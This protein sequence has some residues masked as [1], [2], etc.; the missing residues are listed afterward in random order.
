L[1]SKCEQQ[2]APLVLHHLPTPTP[3]SNANPKANANNN[4]APAPT[5]P[6]NN[7]NND[8]TKAVNLKKVPFDGTEASY[9]WTTQILGFA[10]T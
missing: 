5:T 6:T 3:H 8:Y 2:A 9:I 1:F 10:E 4:A 7:M